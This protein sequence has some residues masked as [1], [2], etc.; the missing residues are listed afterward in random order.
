[1]KF[2][3]DGSGWN[4]KCSKYCIA[5]ENGVLI[6]AYKTKKCMTCNEI[7][8]YAL[9]N[10]LKL[11][12]KNDTILTDSQLIV[13]HLTKNWKV[14]AES[15]KSIVEKCKKLAEK[16]EIKIMWIPRNEN[17]AGIILDNIKD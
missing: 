10:A 11:I 15:L 13:G 1:M 8:Y 5:S 17:K 14:R 4:G 6:K 12:G 3:I 2:Y 9:L 16:K 7:E